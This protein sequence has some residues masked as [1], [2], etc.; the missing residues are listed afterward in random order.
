M[1]VNVCLHGCAIN[2]CVCDLYIVGVCN[3]YL[4]GDMISEYIYKSECVC[5]CVYKGMHVLFA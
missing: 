4:C 2:A 5:V 1:G 3:M